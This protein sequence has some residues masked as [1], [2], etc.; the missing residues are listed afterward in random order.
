MELAGVRLGV[1]QIFMV[2]RLHCETSA[3]MNEQK[4][5]ENWKYL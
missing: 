2:L 5:A 4:C 1:W 3:E